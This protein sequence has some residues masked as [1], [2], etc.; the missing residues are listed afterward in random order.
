MSYNMKQVEVLNWAFS[1]L[2]EHNREEN[3]ANILLRHHLKSTQNEFYLNMRETLDENSVNLFKEDIN[4]H[5]KTGIPVQHLVGYEY[6]YGEKFIVNSDVLVPR[7]ETEELVKLIMDK[8]KES[9]NFKLVDLGTGSGV[10]AITLAKHFKNANVSAVDISK[11]ALIIA[12]KNALTHDILV[13]FYEGN[14]LEPLLDEEKNIDI[15]VSN[16]PYIDYLDLKVLSDTVKDFD[17]HQAL[18]A[19]NKGLAAYEEIMRQAK[20]LKKPAQAIYFEIGYEQ[21]ASIKLMFNH[22]LPEYNVELKQDINGR[23]RMIIAEHKLG[24]E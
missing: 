22:I 3:V 24:G 18:F 7:P 15:I 21:A 13:D 19:E 5:I 6:F 11:E 12:E 8:Y 9:A 1:I 2:K 16:P 14:F 20:R 4:Q 23:D 10:I 17:P